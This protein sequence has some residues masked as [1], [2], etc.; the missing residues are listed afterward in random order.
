MMDKLKKIERNVHCISTLKRI[1]TRRRSK[2]YESLAKR[3]I[4]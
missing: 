3:M 2:E 4:P 1:T